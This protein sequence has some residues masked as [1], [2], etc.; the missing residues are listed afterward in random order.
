MRRV[1]LVTGSLMLMGCSQSVMAEETIAS[2][3]GAIVARIYRNPV[4]EAVL[5]VCT[6]D[7]KK[8]AFVVQGYN[9]GPIKAR[10]IDDRELQVGVQGPITRA[11]PSIASLG[12][13]EFRAHI[14]QCDGY[15][16]VPCPEWAMDLFCV[17]P[18]TSFRK[19][20]CDRR[21]KEPVDPPN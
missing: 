3:S 5:E 7:F 4:R 18:N 15:V 8:C 20:E 10:W 6:A 2:P 9:L 1:M 21:R 17:T 19:A 13:S 11:G 12:N 14:T 16:H